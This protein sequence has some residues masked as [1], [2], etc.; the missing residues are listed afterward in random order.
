ML[1]RLLP[2]NE[3]AIERVARV[4]LGLVLLALVFV[5]PQTRW[6]WIGLL[7]LVT[8]LMGSCPAYTLFGL[9]TCRTKLPAR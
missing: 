6:G 1:Q 2:T 7:P 3:H 9:S 8:G 4:V 5:G